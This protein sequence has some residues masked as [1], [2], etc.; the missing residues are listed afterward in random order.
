MNENG[1]GENNA[2]TR[3]EEKR[4]VKGQE[5]WAGGQVVAEVEW[6]QGMTRGKDGR[7]W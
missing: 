7:E 2:K 5:Q 3:E 6:D 1:E 4:K